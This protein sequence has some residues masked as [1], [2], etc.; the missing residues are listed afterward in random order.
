MVFRF[1]CFICLIII[2]Y[3][4]VYAEVLDQYD[5]GINHVNEHAQ[6]AYDMYFGIERLN[7]IWKNLQKEPYDTLDQYTVNYIHNHI[8][9]NMYYGI[10]TFLLIEQPPE[11]MCIEICPNLKNIDYYEDFLTQ[12]LL[13]F[14]KDIVGIEIFN[15]PDR[16]VHWP[17]KPNPQ[18]YVEILKK[19]KIVRDVISPDV[20]IIMGAHSGPP[21]QTLGYTFLYDLYDAGVKGYYDVFNYHHYTQNEAPDEGW[22]NPDYWYTI[23][24]T[25]FSQHDPDMK[26]WVTEFGYATEGDNPQEIVTEEQQVAYTVKMIPLLLSLP[27]VEKIMLYELFDSPLNTSKYGIFKENGG[28]KIGTDGVKTIIQSL[29]NT[30]F[31]EKQLHENPFLVHYIFDSDRKKTHI[32]WLKEKFVYPKPGKINDVQNVHL[33]VQPYFEKVEAFD[34]LGRENNLIF[35]GDMVDLSITHEPIIIVEHKEDFDNQAIQYLFDTHIAGGFEDGLFHPERYIT[36]AELLKIAFNAFHIALEEG[37]DVSFPDISEDHWVI[38]YARSAKKLG[39]VK[40]DES[41]LFYLNRRV[42]L[43]EALKILITASGLSQESGIDIPYQDVKEDNGFIPYIATAYK[44]GILKN[45]PFLYGDK[46]LFRGEMAEMI[47]NLT[48]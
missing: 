18:K 44:H 3:T 7:V 22:G 21:N 36:R 33:Y 9:N 40:G 38:P 42:S 16:E 28:K 25:F 17:P 15:E 30:H 31:K 32:L 5:F 46:F 43:Y 4:S 14:G 48:Q 47:Y 29:L 10:Q 27:R 37:N 26:I 35:H 20:L 34:V 23:F 11:T 41:G 8:Q 13:E 39:I 45:T 19:T 6:E 24:D 1:M 2:P 12:I